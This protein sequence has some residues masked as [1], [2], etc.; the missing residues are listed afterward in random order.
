MIAK[1]FAM[2]L[3]LTRGRSG[4]ALGEGAVMKV[5]CNRQ[6]DILVLEVS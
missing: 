5:R 3:D 6:E 2:N 1:T 4:G